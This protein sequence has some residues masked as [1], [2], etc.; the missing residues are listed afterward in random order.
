MLASGCYPGHVHLEGAR[1]RAVAAKE[2][3][4]ST[5]KG[6]T[7]GITKKRRTMAT[8]LKVDHIADFDV[9]DTE[10]ALVALLEL[11]LVED[12][13]RNDRV[14]LDSTKTML[15]KRNAGKRPDGHVEGLVPV[16][17]EGL[18]HDAR[19]VGLFC[20][21]GDD[22]EGVR[23]AEDLALGQAIGCDDLG[24]MRLWLGRET[25]DR[26]CNPDALPW[27]LLERGSDDADE[28]LRSTLGSRHGGGGCAS[29]SRAR[30]STTTLGLSGT[31]RMMVVIS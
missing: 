4:L 12:L 1:S 2:A 20:V 10:E 6:A 23:Q 24:E 26:T 21:D 7:A 27:R 9:D 30:L 17:V 11:A 3:F 13:D 31:R 16:R 28:D 22:C 15:D 29:R 14:L 25:N 8:E 18:L 5:L 19:G